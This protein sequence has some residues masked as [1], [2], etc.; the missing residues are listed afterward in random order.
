MRYEDFIASKRLV[1]PPCGIDDVPDLNPKLFP[2]QRDITKWALRRGRSAIWADCGLGKS[3]MALEWARVI[4]ERGHDVLILTPL[5]VARQFREEGQKLD[6]AVTV[7]RHAEDVRPGINVTN[8]ER[9]H[10]LDADQFAGVVLDESSCLKDFASS[11]RNQLIQTF[12]QTPYRLACTATPAPNDYIELGNHAE[13]LG[14]MTRAEMLAMFFIHDSMKTQDW[15]LKRHG[16]DSF[17]RWVCSWACSIRRPS[18][19][20]YSDDGFILPPLVTTE[21]VVSS[22]E[23]AAQA[24]LLFATDALTLE[25]QRRARRG[26]ISARVQCVA[27]IVNA[28]DEQWLVWCD[29]NDESASLTSEIRGAIEIRGSDD[30]DVKEE[31]MLAFLAGKTRVLVTKPSI[32]GY[33]LNIQCCSH[34]AFV[35]ITHS[36]EAWYQAIRRNWRFGQTRPVEC[37]IVTSEAEGAVL[38]NLKR[39]QA[40]AEA[41]SADMIIHMADI[42]KSELTA[43]RRSVTE[44]IPGVE[45]EV[46]SWLTC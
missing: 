10:L 24:G 46:P 18:D 12:A 21:H 43:T 3:W 23:W 15:R 22:D 14:T 5:A 29:L 35:G 30:P 41:M 8:Y 32:A 44:Y 17:W 28:S 19:L 38:A 16:A 40:D 39:K 31:R 13:F 6:L 26:S 4:A 42:T 20:G 7:V 37:H 36:F 1:A 27:D 9:L 34:V 11:T 25:E 33:G 45:M 2:F